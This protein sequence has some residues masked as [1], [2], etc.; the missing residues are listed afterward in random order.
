[1]TRVALL[2]VVAACLAGATPAC[3][4]DEQVATPQV[5]GTLALDIRDTLDVVVKGEGP[6]I[7]VTLTPSKGHGVAADGATL[8]GAGRIEAFP[9]AG[10]ELMTARLDAAAVAGG[11]C[12]DQPVSLA[13][14]LYRREKNAHVGGSLTAYCGAGTFQG[15][16]ARLLRLSGDLVAR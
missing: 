5:A 8:T 6:D 2:Y 11:P 3:G 12:K 4:K 16:P 15:V 13:L 14:S 1:M 7:E 10:G 9:E